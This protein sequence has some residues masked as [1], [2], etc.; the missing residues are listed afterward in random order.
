MR[1]RRVLC[2]GGM[3][4]KPP[5][6]CWVLGV[7]FSGAWILGVLLWLGVSC[8]TGLLAWVGPG[9]YSIKP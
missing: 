5:T 9:V 1:I 7:G 6:S 8:N 3:S 2:V 4:P